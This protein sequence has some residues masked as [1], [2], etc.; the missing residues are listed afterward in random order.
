[1]KKN[2]ILIILLLFLTLTTSGCTKILK[3]DDKKA[4]TNP[5]TGQSLPENILC[6]PTDK[7]TL[8]I[9]EKYEVDLSKLPEC[10]EFTVTSGGYEGIWTTIFVKPLAWIIIKLGDLVKNYGIAVM[11]VTLIIRLIMVPVTKKTAMQS[12]N[13]QKAKPELDKLEKKYANKQDQESMMQK[14]QEMLMIYKK[15]D[16]NPM[17]GCLFSLIQI[18]LFFAFYEAMNRLPAIFEEVL[19][20]FQLGTS[21]MVAFKSGDWY[22]LI[23]VLLVIV[24]TYFSFKLNSGAS[25]SKEQADQMKMMSNVMIVMIGVMSFSISTGIALYWIVNSGFTVLQNLY[26][27]RSKLN[28]RKS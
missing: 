14:S 28:A 25:M 6:R 22:Y 13:L 11:L 2:K 21:P 10:E 7:E 16:I 9:Y 15:Y 5:T 8:E 27:K 17:S 26:V 3:D 12:E 4:V 1:M 20:P 18:P 23:F 19:G 24:V